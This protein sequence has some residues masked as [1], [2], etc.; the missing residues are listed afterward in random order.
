MSTLLRALHLRPGEVGRAL[1]VAGMGICYAAATSL[2]DDV[3]QS[4]FVTR[5]GAQSMPIVFLFKGLLDVVAATLYLPITRGRS[6][7]RVW[8]VV[9]AIYITTVL[10]GWGL[11]TSGTQLSA[12]LLF[13]GHECA[14]TILTIHWGV[15][16][17]DVFDASQARRL[18]P[19]MFTAARVGG[20][21]AGVLLRALAAPLGVLNLLVGAAA[22]AALAGL[23]SYLRMSSSASAGRGAGHP[24]NS[25]SFAAEG[26]HQT[27]ADDEGV[28]A[29]ARDAVEAA[30]SSWRS[31]RHAAKSPLVRIIAWSTAAMV[32]VRYGLHMVA[33][34]QISTSFA[35]DKEMVAEFLGMFGAAANTVSILLGIFVVPRILARLGVGFAN[36][37]YAATTVISYASL[38]LLPSLG[39]AAFARF[40]RVQFK[41]A[42]K[43]PLSTLFY[44]AEPPHRR[45][46]ARAFIF[47]AAIPAA[48]VLAALAFELGGRSGDGLRLVAIMGAAVSLFFV[49]SCAVQNTRW[50]RRM[51]ELLD[52]KLERTPATHAAKA[53]AVAERLRPFVEGADA[54]AAA[55]LGRVQRGLSSRDDRVRAVAEEVLAEVIPRARAHEIASA[56]RNEPE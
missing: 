19:L 20:I 29:A 12:Y 44:G 7:A 11:T 2:G 9:L 41:D 53:D 35:D 34:D 48:T 43:T 50:R 32:L 47:G 15:F 1:W 30:Q 3:A 31:W 6:P 16:I 46:P 55:V 8:R 25:M 37:A 56:V 42:L 54:D 36:L 51:V 26:P 38:L 39:T 49:V 21:F 17:L 22:F 14:W 23:L 52:W 4:L 45:A 28:A 27:A 13:I 10:A 33:I 18:F 40:T 24:A 5:V